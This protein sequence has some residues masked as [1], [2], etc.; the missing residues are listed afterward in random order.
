MGAVTFAVGHSASQPD[1]LSYL[2]STLNIP[3]GL[4]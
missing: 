3:H 1:A 4:S 2:Q